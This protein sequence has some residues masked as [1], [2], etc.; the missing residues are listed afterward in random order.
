MPKTE[1][2]GWTWEDYE[3]WLKLEWARCLT[4][5]HDNEKEIHRFLNHHPCLLPGGEGGPQSIGGHHGPF[6]GVV[7]TEPPLPG[8]FRRTPDFIWP[9]KVSGLFRPVFLELERPS[10]LWFR[11]D[12][13]QTEELSQAITQV[14][15]WRTWLDSEANKLLFYEK[16]G[17]SDWIRAYHKIEPVFHLIYGRRREFIENLRLTRQRE[18]VRPGWLHW[19]TYDRLHPAA[20]ARQWVSVRITTTEWQVVAVPPTFTIEPDSEADLQGL[21]GLDRAIASNELI[22]EARRELLLERLSTIKPR[23]AAPSNLWESILREEHAGDMASQ[24]VE[25]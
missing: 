17:I 25:S 13:Q 14:G 21:T 16:Y 7:V 4:V 24:P 10:K 1:P 18:S 15:E 12:G 9:T 5:N 6:P 20:N 8:T 19:S 2:P 3:Y 11:Q 22:S 23:P